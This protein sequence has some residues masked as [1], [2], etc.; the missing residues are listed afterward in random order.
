MCVT[1][2]GLSRQP[3]VWERL[4]S[5]NNLRAAR[6]ITE[7]S[8]VTVNYGRTAIR[9]ILCGNDK[10]LLVIVGPCSVHD[11]EAII[12]FAERLALVSR[13]L[14]DDLAVVMRTYFEKSR[15]ASGWPGMAIVPD[16]FGH[17][18][19]ARGFALARSISMKITDLGL[20][21][22]MEW[23]SA[24][25]PAYLDD[26]VSWGCIGAR[27]VES[28]IHRQLAS[29]LPMPVGM[30]NATDGSIAAAV[31]AILT[32]SHPQPWIGMA[33]EGTVAFRHT[34]GNPD[35]HLVL[36]GGRSGTNYHLE[37]EREA[38]R[39]L[40]ASGLPERLI[41]DASH[42]NSDKSHE[43]QRVVAHDIADRIATGDTAVCGIM[44]ESFL[45]PGT[46]NAVATQPL[47]RGQ[48][49][50]DQCM[51]WSTTAEVLTEL[52]AAARSRTRTIPRRSK[53]Q[54]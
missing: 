54:R 51:S 32:A 37:A 20:P 41:I 19:P 49:I 44:L 47:I 10:R 5:P 30:K 38:Y 12:E 16:V 13:E 23:V 15:T 46:Q 8:A 36:R 52:A 40:A 21:I 27:T 18:D 11:S 45:S 48:S 22:A 4:P 6:Q 33:P 43:R 53:R 2:E 25:G 24:V 50:T 1:E 26:L 42:A 39:I 14:S 9:Q 28:Q 29:G 31:N 7:T 3:T 17:A 35:C 34:A